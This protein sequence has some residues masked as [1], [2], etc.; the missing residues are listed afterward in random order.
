MLTNQSY[1]E[2]SSFEVPSSQVY[3]QP[4][5]WNLWQL[6]YEGSDLINSLIKISCVQKKKKKKP[7]KLLEVGGPG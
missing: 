4:D 1:G 3:H 5:K 7:S 2:D 6:G